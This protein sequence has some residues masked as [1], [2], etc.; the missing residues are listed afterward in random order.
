MCSVF[1]SFDDIDNVNLNT[2]EYVLMD[3]QST[4]IKTFSNDSLK[5]YKIENL[6]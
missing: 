1:V 2:D 3:N 6:E 5:K 4:V